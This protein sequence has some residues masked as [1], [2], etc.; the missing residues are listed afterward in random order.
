MS[1]GDTIAVMNNGII[2][3]LAPP[4]EIYDRPASMFVADFIGSPPMNF[5]RFHASLRPGVATVA[6]DGADLAIPDPREALP[7]SDLVL[8]VRPE[9]LRF[10]DASRLR[11]EVFGAEYMGTTQIVTVRT[12]HGSV[13]ARLS[14]DIRIRPGEQVGLA[15]RSDRLSVFEASSGRAIRTELHDAVYSLSRHAGGAHG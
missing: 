7:A 15:M 4:R 1:L 5:L 10:S 6:I 14:S 2:E 11:G 8:G 12:A 3:Q 9:H 13:K